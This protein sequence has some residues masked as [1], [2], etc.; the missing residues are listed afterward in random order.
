MPF[1]ISDIDE[2]R[3]NIF[4]QPDTARGVRYPAPWA[5]AV[6]TRD[7]LDCLDDQ[8]GSVLL[9]QESYRSEALA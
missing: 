7:W 9:N 1:L 2:K 5:V 8:A 3:R 4:L 6:L